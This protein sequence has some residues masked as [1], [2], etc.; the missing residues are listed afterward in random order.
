[1][2]LA[3]SPHYFLS[4]AERDRLVES[5]RLAETG[6]SG[7]I[8]VHVE[9]RC[10]IDALERAAQVFD[11]LGMRATRQRNGVLLYLALEDRVFAIY[12]D[13]GIDDAVQRPFWNEI[14]DRMQEHF[15]DGRFGD[16]LC[17]AVERVGGVLRSCFPVEP[18]D[19]NELPNEPSIDL[20]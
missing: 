20:Q 18:G 9:R 10:R 13:Q 1:M 6:T 12:G 2:K 4:K 15:R 5:I 19:V 17:L 3:K 8:R 11:L 16:G 7:E 14:R